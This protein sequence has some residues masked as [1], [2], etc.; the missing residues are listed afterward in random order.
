MLPILGAV[1]ANLSIFI[2]EH[3]RGGGGSVSAH[4]IANDEAR[5]RCVPSEK[6]FYSDK[7]IIFV[8]FRFVL[9]EAGLLLTAR[10]LDREERDSYMVTMVMGRK[11]ILRGKQAIQVKVSGD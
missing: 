9:S 4:L 10:P 6:I 3:K 8:V 7:N 5:E 2:H 1:V 11:G